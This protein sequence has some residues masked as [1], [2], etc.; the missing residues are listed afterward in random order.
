MENKAQNAKSADFNHHSLEDY[1]PMTKNKLGKVYVFNQ[2]SSYMGE[3]QPRVGHIKDCKDIEEVFQNLKFDVV[4][5]E[6]LTYKEILEKLSN[7][8]KMDYSEY[9]CLIFFV[10]THGK[11]SKIF[12]QDIVYYPD[13]YWNTLNESSTLVHKPK[14]IFLQSPHDEEAYY[15]RAK[16]P[17]SVPTTYSIPE[18]PDVLFM[19]SCFDK[20]ISWRS[21]VTG[22][23]FIQCIFK[24]YKQH[25]EN[26]D[27][28]TILT[29]INR[30]MESDFTKSL[31]LAAVGQKKM[32]TIVSTLN[33]V[34]YFSSKN[35]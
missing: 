4:K 14:L 24:E 11:G 6:D 30:S 8:A 10:L 28:L 31:S 5:Y 34:L 12:A 2:M 22:S 15:V 3:G 20:F 32:C 23:S 26:T 13:V 35:K 21:H 7:I 27:L 29:F 19:Y 16:P 18:I 17:R 25:A 9:G 33:K 1:Y